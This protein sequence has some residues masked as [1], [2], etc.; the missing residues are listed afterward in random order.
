MRDMCRIDRSSASVRDE[1]PDLATIADAF[2]TT[3]ARYD[4]FAEDHPHL[5]RM[6]SKVY[7][8]FERFV[9]PG[10]TVLE[11]NA[12]T[13]TD[14]LHLAQRGYR[15]HATDIAPGMLARVHDKVA[16]HGLEGRVSVQEC[17]FLALD[18][19]EGGPFDAVF[20]DLGGLNCCA[21]L[22][23]VFRGVDRVLRPGG[24]AVVV[25]MPPVCLW[26]L[27]LVFAGQFRLATRRLAAGGV[28]AHLEGRQ[29]TVYYFTPRQVLDAFGEAY[30][31]LAVEG[32]SVLTPTAESKSLAQRHSG[33]Y[34]LLATAD[35]VVALHA[36]FSRWGD[37]FL[38][39]V[40][41]RGV[42]ASEART[43]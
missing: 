18:E 3:A 26:E 32:I 15:V 34:R 42:S 28:R 4:A 19:V 13:G 36:P 39:A 43:P 37:F 9:P 41:R 2:S 11:L 31:P 10:A 30:E 17:S 12:G 22:R 25:V 8:A 27:A 14:A 29:F 6:R 38:A 1:G 40:R 20:S 33:V 16:A 35:D 21:D 23:P 7:A 5:T 24:V